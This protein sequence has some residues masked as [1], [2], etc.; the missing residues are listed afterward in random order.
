MA[1]RLARSYVDW[2]PFVNGRGRHRDAIEDPREREAPSYRQPR[3]R[4]RDDSR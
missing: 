4:R 2:T 3:G 1:A